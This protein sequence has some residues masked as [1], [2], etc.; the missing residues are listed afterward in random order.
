MVIFFLGTTLLSTSGKEAG[1][2]SGDTQAESISAATIVKIFLI[3][4]HPR[5]SIEN[6]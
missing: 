1:C 2:L 5:S 3:A 6:Q 4:F